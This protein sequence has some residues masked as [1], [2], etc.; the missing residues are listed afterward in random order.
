[1]ND[2][3]PD[4]SYPL[5]TAHPHVRAHRQPTPSHIHARL[6]T[7]HVFR[8]KHWKKLFSETGKFTRQKEKRTSHQCLLTLDGLEL[9]FCEFVL[10]AFLASVQHAPLHS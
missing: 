3:H 7:L 8:P 10:D 1:M 5:C 4:T 2:L 6:Q 9:F